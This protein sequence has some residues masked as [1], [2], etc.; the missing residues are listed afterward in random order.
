MHVLVHGLLVD[1]FV[2]EALERRSDA[3]LLPHLEVLSEVLISAP[4]VGPDHADSLVSSH[5]MEVRVSH[6]VLLPINWEPPV[7]VGRIIRLVGLSIDPSPLLD[8]LFLF[9]IA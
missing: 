2:V 8:H 9:Y 4:P 1:L 7:S 6:V 3:V 5:L